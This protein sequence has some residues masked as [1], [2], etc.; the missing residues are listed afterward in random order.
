MEEEA[1]A[2]PER[3]SHI[4]EPESQSQNENNN[5]DDDVGKHQ[6]SRVGP[7]T[8]LASLSARKNYY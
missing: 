2:R 7:N 6:P 8:D 3:R 1:H 5:N 4:I